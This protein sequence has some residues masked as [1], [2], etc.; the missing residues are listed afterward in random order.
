[1]V[2]E[3]RIVRKKVAK[4]IL[5]SFLFLIVLFMFL[6]LPFDF[7]MP[8][9][10]ATFLGTLIILVLLLIFKCVSILTE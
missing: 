1:M 4:F 6:T 7:L 2:E 9:I 5:L 10:I 8:S 3:K